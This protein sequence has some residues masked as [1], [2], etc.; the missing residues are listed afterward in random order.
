VKKVGRTSKAWRS[1]AQQSLPFSQ[2]STKA[3]GSGEALEGDRHV[4]GSS[5]GTGHFAVLCSWENA[6]GSP[7][8]R[9][10]GRSTGNSPPVQAGGYGRPALARPGATGESLG[11]LLGAPWG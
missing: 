10:R 8:G 2:I 6:V 5:E 4:L 7:G 1:E 11:E 9:F 3:L